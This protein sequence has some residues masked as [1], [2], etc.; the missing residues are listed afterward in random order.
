[1]IL[2]N[3]LIKKQHTSG[4]GCEVQV[5]FS[6]NF[7]LII[8]IPMTS[9]KEMNSDQRKRSLY[10]DQLLTVQDLIEFKEQLILD[11]KKLLK[12]NSGQPSHRWLKAFEVKKLLRVSDSKLQY[13]RD[14][15]VIPFKKLGGVTYYDY[16]E[17]QEIMKSDRFHDQ[18]KLA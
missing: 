10:R 4:H 11:I 8:F 16:N 2:S 12:E 14:K 5:P 15:G 17:I 18:L 1:M 9:I 7:V 3:Y 6:P 13:L